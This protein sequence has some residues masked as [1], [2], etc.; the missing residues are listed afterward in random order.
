MSIPPRLRNLE[1]YSRDGFTRNQ[2]PLSIL[3]TLMV[4]FKD[5]PYRVKLAQWEHFWLV[6]ELTTTSFEIDCLLFFFL[7]SL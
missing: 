3:Q 1:L 4:T 6:I 5:L 2:Y 7:V